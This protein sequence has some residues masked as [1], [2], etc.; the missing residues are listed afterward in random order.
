MTAQ[1]KTT[2]KTYFESGDK[3]NESQFVD[4]I[5]SYQDANDALGAI[6]S[7]AQLGSKGVIN[8]TASGSVTF[9]SA[10]TVG[11]QLL[12]AETTAAAQ[13]IVNNSFDIQALVSS[14]LPAVDN[15]LTLG[16]SAKRFKEA[17]ISSALYLGGVNSANRLSIYEEGTFTPRVSATGGTFDAAYNSRIGTYTRIGNLAHIEMNIDVATVSGAPSGNLTLAGL[18][19]SAATNGTGNILKVYQIGGISMYNTVASCRNVF[20]GVGSDSTTGNFLCDAAGGSQSVIPAATFTSAFFVRITG[21]Y[22]I[23]T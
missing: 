17:F 19:F 21:D 9:A 11:K 22:T 6:A 7:A 16:S 15:T 1:N 4:L 12:A 5:D 13:S 2:I 3:P 23:N 14:P 18:P 20:I 10:G 8:V